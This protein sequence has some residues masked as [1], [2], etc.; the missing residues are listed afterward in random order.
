MFA[1]FFGCEEK[2]DVL[3]YFKN[4]GCGIRGGAG[5]NG[6]C[7]RAVFA[8]MPE[9]KEKLECLR[10]VVASALGVLALDSD[11]WVKYYWLWSK[12]GGSV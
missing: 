9:Y 4:F 7:G 11:K 1:K 2:F 10:N 5:I 3:E 8:M 6:V 12:V